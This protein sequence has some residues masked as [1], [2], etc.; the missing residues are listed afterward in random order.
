MR[1]LP[2]E[3]G[4]RNLGRSP[5]RLVLSVAGG[6]LVV[7]LVLAAGMV[8]PVLITVSRGLSGKYD[9]HKRIARWTLPVWLFVHV[10]AA[11]WLL[12]AALSAMAG[13]LVERWLFFAQARHLVTLYY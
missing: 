8:P 2:W 11:P 7:L 12:G 1:L 9:K 3:Y 10:D 6:A 5:L 4:V 13:A